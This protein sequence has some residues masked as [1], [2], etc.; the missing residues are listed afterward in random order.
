M[1][2]MV[3]II[4][5]ALKKKVQRLSDNVLKELTIFADDNDYEKEWVLERFKEEFSKKVRKWGNG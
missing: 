3:H 5:I 4:R 1:I 2:T